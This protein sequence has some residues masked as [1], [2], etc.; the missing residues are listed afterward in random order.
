MLLGLGVGE[1][2]R[3][4]GTLRAWGGQA[5]PNRAALTPLQALFLKIL[6]VLG[7]YC[8]AQAFSSWAE[9][10]LLFLFLKLFI[11]YWA[12]PRSF[13]VLKVRWCYYVTLG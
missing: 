13:L 5:P 3:V 4:V 12:E 8:C 9:R 7:L 10:G 11:L 6:A 2:W 1:Q